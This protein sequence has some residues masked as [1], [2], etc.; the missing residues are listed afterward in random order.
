MHDLRG[1]TLMGPRYGQQADSS[2]MLTTQPFV[3]GNSML[4]D[5]SQETESTVCT[6]HGTE[7]AKSPSRPQ[8][9][10]YSDKE[11]T[12]DALSIDDDQLAMF[13]KQTSQ[14]PAFA[15][16]DLQGELN[17][18]IQQKPR[19]QGRNETGLQRSESD[20]S[21]RYRFSDHNCWHSGGSGSTLARNNSLSRSVATVSGGNASDIDTASITDENAQLED[22]GITHPYAFSQVQVESIGQTAQAVPSP[23]QSHTKRS[24]QI[25]AL[26]ERYGGAKSEGETSSRQGDLSEEEEYDKPDKLRDQV[27]SESP[28]PGAGLKAL[29]KRTNSDLLPPLPQQP[30]PSLLAQGRQSRKISTDTLIYEKAESD[31]DKEPLVNP[32]E[33]LTSVRAK[34]PELTKKAQVVPQE[35]TLEEMLE[36]DSDSNSDRYEKLG[37]QGDTETATAGKSGSSNKKSNFIAP[38][39]DLNAIRKK[40]EIDLGSPGDSF[41]HV[42]GGVGRNATPDADDDIAPYARTPRKLSRVTGEEETD[43]AKPYARVPHRLSVVKQD[44]DDIVDVKSSFRGRSLDRVSEDEGIS[45]GTTVTTRAAGSGVQSHGSDS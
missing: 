39:D 44:G 11:S 9:F 3:Q 6:R 21:S 2:V 18:L 8:S 32:Y 43:E 7:S 16:D 25:S 35:K 19:R 26:I 40:L 34:V 29:R 41:D 14:T 28:N 4:W 5:S 45:D 42:R 15:A 23:R 36:S 24:S 20:S 17:E 27:T 12:R 30:L 31:D 13:G 38:Y 22:E 1:M 10:P 33:D 37:L